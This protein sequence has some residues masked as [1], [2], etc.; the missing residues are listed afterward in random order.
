MA[1]NVFC[2][3][4]ATRGGKTAMWLGAQYVNEEKIMRKKK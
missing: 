1:S 4:V 3:L 2:A